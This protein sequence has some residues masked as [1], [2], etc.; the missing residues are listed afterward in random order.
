[1]AKWIEASTEHG[2]Q[3]FNLDTVE[4]ISAG[5]DSSRSNAWHVY[6]T[7]G[8]M[9]YALPGNY[10]SEESAAKHAASLVRI[11]QT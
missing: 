7:I 3:W 5:K 2:H 1:M 6:L 8:T 10:G 9:A 4:R 11:S